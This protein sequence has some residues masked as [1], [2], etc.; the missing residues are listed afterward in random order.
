[1]T[2]TLVLN[3]ILQVD[4]GSKKGLRLLRACERLRVLLSQLPTAS[5]T[6]ENMSDAGDVNISFSR[7]ELSRV[8]Q[9]QVAAFRSLLEAVLADALG[10]D[11]IVAAEISGGGMRMTIVQE[12]VTS[13]IGKVCMLEDIGMGG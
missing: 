1:M 9:G 13:V 7:E 5:I 11:G 2:P 4:P 8:C 12:V 3:V 10:E 6:A